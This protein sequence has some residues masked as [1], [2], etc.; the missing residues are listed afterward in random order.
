MAKLIKEVTTIIPAHDMADASSVP[1]INAGDGTGE[2]PSQA[3]L[4]L[5]TI[6]HE[7]GSLEGLTVAMVGDL[8][9]GRTVHSLSQALAMWGAELVLVSPPPLSM[10]E[11]VLD[12]LSAR[13]V[14]FTQTQ[15]LCEGL[16]RADVAYITR[17]Q[18]ERFEDPADYLRFKGLYVIDAQTVRAAK[19]GMIVMHPLPRVDEIAR[20]VDDLPNAA[21]FRQARYA[22]F[23][24]MA[25]LAMV[26]GAV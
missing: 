21:Y 23:V 4:D 10:P 20:D 5:F 6:E 9:N 18:K 7:R 16:A 1:V 24:R 14:R 19:E 25:L 13:G 3:M 17:V 15:D 12:D 2:H 22:V 8:K 26:L 11:D